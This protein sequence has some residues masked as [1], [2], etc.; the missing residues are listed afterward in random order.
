MAGFPNDQSKAAGA[1]PVYVTE[2]ESGG[3]TP[4]AG[5][6][7][8]IVTGGTPITIVTG[9]VNGGYVTNPPN[10]ASQGIA[11]AENAYLSLVG[12]PG[13]VD[14]NANGTT[15]PLIP[16]QTFAIPALAAGV[17]LKANAATSGHKLTV[18]VW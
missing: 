17:L 13:S 4:V 9:P 18:V 7:S 16:G 14:A 6:A 8:A 11:A 2:A 3:V 1:I 15:S 12:N 10:L 5:T